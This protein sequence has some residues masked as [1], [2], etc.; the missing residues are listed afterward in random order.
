MNAG[1]TSLEQLAGIRE[2]EV[3][4]WHGM[5]P[6]AIDELREALADRGMSFSAG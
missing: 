4:A 2:A 6:R 1:V 3:R 5:G